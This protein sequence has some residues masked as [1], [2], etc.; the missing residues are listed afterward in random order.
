MLIDAILLSAAVV[1]MFA[2]F[3]GALI[4]SG[5]FQTTNTAVPGEART[6]LA[7]FGSRDEFVRLQRAQIGRNADVD[8]LRERHAR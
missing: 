4:W 6:L 1:S 3:A 7:R 8:Y 2:V 5:A